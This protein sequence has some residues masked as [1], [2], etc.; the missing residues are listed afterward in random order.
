MNTKTNGG[1]YRAHFESVLLLLIIDSFRITHS[2]VAVIECRK[3]K[4][5]EMVLRR[6]QK[7]QSRKIANII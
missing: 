3:N 6:T 4:F 5:D 1:A 7:Q 2:D